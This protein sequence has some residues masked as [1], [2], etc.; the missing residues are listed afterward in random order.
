MEQEEKCN[1]LRDQC[2]YEIYSMQDEINHL[3]ELVNEYKEAAE[4]KDREVHNC[5]KEL[6]EIK[7]LNS[8]Y[9]HQID[10]LERTV[11]VYDKELQYRIR[12][13][14]NWLGSY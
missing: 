8:S 14:D 4:F 3:Q 6:S 10:F 5:E 12:E 9:E 11:E 2:S 1:E 13:A 7:D